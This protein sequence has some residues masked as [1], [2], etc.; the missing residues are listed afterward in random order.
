MEVHEPTGW[1]G[2]EL[3]DQQKRTSRIRRDNV[4]LGV[5]RARHSVVNQMLTFGYKQN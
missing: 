3:V 1:F 2:R 4:W 5:V